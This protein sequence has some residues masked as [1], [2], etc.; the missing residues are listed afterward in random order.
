MDG[1]DIQCT[2]KGQFVF[3]GQ[4]IFGSSCLTDRLAMVGG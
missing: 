2:I 4:K 1:K 3:E